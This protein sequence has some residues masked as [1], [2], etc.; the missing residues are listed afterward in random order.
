VS[1]EPGD[2]QAFYLERRRSVDVTTAVVMVLLLGGPIGVMFYIIY[3]QTR[4]SGSDSGKVRQKRF[5]KA[6]KEGL[7]SGSVVSLDDVVNLYGGSIAL[8]PQDLRHRYGLTRHL[9]E[10]LVGLVSR[11]EGIVDSSLDDSTLQRWK[12]KVSEFIQRNETAAPYADLPTPERDIMTDI[13]GYL[14]KNDLASVRRKS[15]ELAAAIQARNA[16]LKAEHRTNMWSVPTSV[17][18]LIL[19]IV[20]GIIAVVK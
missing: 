10:F 11:R 16:N 1:A 14:E 13:S 8:S 19:T 5:S 3:V 9:R 2:Q 17:V 20:F 18:G 7:E 12:E 15:L 6:L 4:D